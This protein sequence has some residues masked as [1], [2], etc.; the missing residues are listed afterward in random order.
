MPDDAGRGTYQINLF[1]PTLRRSWDIKFDR[2]IRGTANLTSPTLARWGCSPRS[3]SRTIAQ[4]YAQCKVETVA[5]CW[6]HRRWVAALEAS[7]TLQQQKRQSS[8]ILRHTQ[9]LS[10][11]Q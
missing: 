4:D 5:C 3:S 6:V 10:N 2:K 11:K 1:D 7:I 9:P 8:P